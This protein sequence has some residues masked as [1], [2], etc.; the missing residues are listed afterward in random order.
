M[1][2]IDAIRRNLGTASF[3]NLDEPDPQRTGAE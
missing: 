1:L 2:D 3:V